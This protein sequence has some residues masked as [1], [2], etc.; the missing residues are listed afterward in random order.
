MYKLFE[1]LDRRLVV[2][3][4]R[5]PRTAEFVI[6]LGAIIGV[7]LIC[8]VIIAAVISIPVWVLGASYSFAG[9]AFTI[10]LLEALVLVFVLGRIR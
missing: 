3:I 10:A 6:W 4:D 2:L 5:Y 7:S 8:G 9:I 1:A